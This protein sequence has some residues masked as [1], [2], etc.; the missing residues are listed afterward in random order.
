M[1]HQK[2]SFDKLNLN[3]QNM[4]NF[5]EIQEWKHLM[6][7]IQLLLCL[8]FLFKKKYLDR[9]LNDFELIKQKK[10]SQSS[11][12]WQSFNGM[13]RQNNTSEVI[14]DCVS[15]CERILVYIKHAR[16]SIEN[17]WSINV[18]SDL[19]FDTTLYRL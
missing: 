13:G 14:Y 11:I 15:A 2:D 12:S 4:A 6:S 16:E 9:F 8:F 3:K 10:M 18:W 5:I 1:K 7:F 19:E 17:V